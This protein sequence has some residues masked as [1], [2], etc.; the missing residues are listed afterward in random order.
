MASDPKKMLAKKEYFVK[1]VML[2]K[3]ELRKNSKR[4]RRNKRPLI[5]PSCAGMLEPSVTKFLETLPIRKQ[6]EKSIPRNLFRRPIA[7]KR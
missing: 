2:S 1:S 6:H 7:P 3:R 5:V 4:K